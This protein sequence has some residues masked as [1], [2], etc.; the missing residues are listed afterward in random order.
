MLVGGEGNVASKFEIIYPSTS[1]DVATSA[2]PFLVATPAKDFLCCIGNTAS[3]IFDIGCR[4]QSR[5]RT[6]P[7]VF[8]LADTPLLAW[9]AGVV[10]LLFLALA[11]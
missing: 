11:C 1:V 10:V 9:G 5:T 8:A 3:R 2:F 4:T 7:K 6:V